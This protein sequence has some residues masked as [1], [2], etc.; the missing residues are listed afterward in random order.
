MNQ[1]KGGIPS[2]LDRSGCG[3][4]MSS[5]SALLLLL[6]REMQEPLENTMERRADF[7]SS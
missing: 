5:V 4:G 1:G 3:R 2:A 7:T 6:T